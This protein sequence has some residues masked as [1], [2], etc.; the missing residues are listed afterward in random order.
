MDISGLGATQVIID[1]AGSHRPFHIGSGT[2]V[3]LS[4]L[5]IQHGS[6]SG[7]GGGILNSGTLTMKDSTLSG[8]LA[9]GA[10]G[11]IAH[12]DGNLNSTLT[13]KNSTLSN[14]SAYS[15]GGIFMA[16]IPATLINSTLSGNS[17]T[18]SVAVFTR[19]RPR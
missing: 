15:G 12:Q 17:A 19:C 8:N 7:N 1:G 14:N 18:R 16:G 13:V 3:N 4:G 11:G 6:T 10:G 5:T 2:T 9:S